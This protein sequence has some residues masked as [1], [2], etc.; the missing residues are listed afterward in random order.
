MSSS[1]TRYDALPPMSADDLPSAASILKRLVD[2]L[3]FRYRWASDGLSRDDLAFTPCDGSMSLGELLDHLR[4]LARWLQVNVSAGLRGDA[5]VTYPECCAELPDPAGD[6]ELLREQSLS[7]WGA[8]SDELSGA[9]AED[10]QRVVLVGG[11]EPTSF[12]F[13]NALN[14]PLADALTHVGQLNSWRR[15]LGRPAPKPDV[16]R[17]RPPR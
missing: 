15:Q 1:I 16:F 17:G 3:A 13:W 8:L 11:K 2:G 14:G 5:P 4:Y 9:S 6:P 12:P 10:L 7:A